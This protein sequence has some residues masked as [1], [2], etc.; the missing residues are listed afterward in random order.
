[1]SALSIVVLVLLEASEVFFHEYAAF[2]CGEYRNVDCVKQ[3]AWAT[4]AANNKAR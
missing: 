4:V 1:M 3:R 2:A